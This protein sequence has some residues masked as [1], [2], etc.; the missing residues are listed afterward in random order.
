MRVNVCLPFIMYKSE[1]IRGAPEWTRMYW[2]AEGFLYANIFILFIDLS[3]RCCY[4]ELV[5]WSTLCSNISGDIGILFTSVFL[6]ILS[7]I[8]SYRNE[9]A[10]EVDLPVTCN[11]RYRL[12]VGDTF[13]MVALRGNPPMLQLLL[14]SIQRIVKS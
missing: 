8:Q 6:Y 11:L 3:Y 7:I 10:I 12:I 9:A 2:K 13:L 4:F 14:S 1:E 5:W